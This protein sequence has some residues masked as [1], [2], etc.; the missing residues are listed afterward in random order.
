MLIF[1]WQV[2]SL[3]HFYH[4]KSP[5]EAQ[6]LDASLPLKANW[7]A[8]KSQHKR[9][10][11]AVTTKEHNPLLGRIA[12]EQSACPF[13]ELSRPLNSVIVAPKPRATEAHVVPPR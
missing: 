5:K 7:N 10:P 12:G 2:F 8:E 4:L 6:V 1:L 11:Q 9:K 13:K 3:S